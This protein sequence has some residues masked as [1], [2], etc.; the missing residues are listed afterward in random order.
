VA[1]LLFLS[2]LSLFS[3]VGFAKDP[4]QG[5]KACFL[6]YNAKTQ[7]FEKTIGPD[8]CRERLTP[9]S[10]FKVPLAIMAFDS[11]AL[12]DEKQILKWDGKKRD[13]PELNHDHDA[14]TWMRDSVVWFSQRLTP[15]IGL[16]RIQ[17]YLKDFH[18]GNQDMSAGLT[19]AWL[20]PPD[21][22]PALKISAYEQINFLKALWSDAFPVSKKAMELTRKILYVET[23]PRGFILSGK[24]GSNSFKDNPKRRI[25]WFVGHLQKGDQEYF[26]A[27][28]FRDTQDPTDSGPGGPLTRNLVKGLLTEQGLW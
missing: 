18:Y 1:K 6:L 16:Q 25:G 14:V 5:K 2:V 20:V 28:N 10:T 23:S 13:R 19:D 21:R 3:C 17:K 15:E 4:F 26:L 9:C 27:A 7:S 24:T 22:E 11:G 8:I 12:K